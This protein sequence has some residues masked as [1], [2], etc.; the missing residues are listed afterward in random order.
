M[1]EYQKLIAVVIGMFV[2]GFI[3]VGVGKEGDS[4]DVIAERTRLL[5][6][7]SM[8]GMAS[9]K[10]PVAIKNKTGTEVYFP[11]SNESDK[12]TYVTLNY[13]GTEKGDK[14]KTASCTLTLALGGISK[15][16]IDDEVVIDKQKIMSE[17]K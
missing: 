17:I 13:K 12:D 5:T 15:L 10:C 9:Q 3:M 6:F 1:G 8:Q 16:V 11:T 4:P 7:S 14:F 2:L